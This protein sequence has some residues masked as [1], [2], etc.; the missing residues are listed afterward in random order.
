MNGRLDLGWM[1]VFVEAGRLGS[2]SAA[3]ASLGLTQPAVSYQIRRLE[4]QLGFAVLKRR[5]QGV[6]LTAD[7]RKLFDIVERGVT[8]IDG[9][10]RSRVGSSM[11]QSVRLR[12]DYAF[13]SFWLIPRMHAFRERH[14][15]IDIQI[16][17]TQRLRPEEME[18]G[19]VAVVF[20]ERSEY[21]RRGTILLAEEVVP[22]CTPAFLE[23]SG[24]GEPAALTRTRL[25]HLDAASPTPWFDWWRYFDAFGLAG[26][27]AG[28]GDLS[29]NTYSLVIQAALESQGVALGWMGLV[30]SYL[31]SRVLVPAGRPVRAPER[32]YTLLAPRSEHEN[33]RRFMDWL[34]E[35]TT[36]TG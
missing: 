15:Q 26:P 14:P 1:R 32:G 22:V 17:A 8:E 13:S 11:R 4:E 28:Q 2:F 30:D 27:S 19:D 35:E 16:V 21:G 29:F 23:R 25:V 18:E 36:R 34:V 31:R 10:L 5:H 6:E 9:F 7:G 12:T 20:A 3:A 33:A 24:A